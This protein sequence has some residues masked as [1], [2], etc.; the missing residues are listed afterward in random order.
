MTFEWLLGGFLGGIFV[1]VFWG[2]WE[3][4]QIRQRLDRIGRMIAHALDQDVDHKQ[5]PIDA[6]NLVL[7]T[8]RTLH[9]E[10]DDHG[11]EN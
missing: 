4:E 1:L 3:L 8:L 9:R 10:L 11:G 2:L 6:N 5:Q 7:K